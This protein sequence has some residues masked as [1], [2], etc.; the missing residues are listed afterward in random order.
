MIFT[1]CFFQASFRY[2]KVVGGAIILGWR[3]RTLTDAFR[4]FHIQ[5]HFTNI[6]RFLGRYRWDAFE[7]GLVLLQ[8]A[9][10]LL[11]KDGPLTIA[12]DVLGRIK[13]FV[14]CSFILVVDA[15][16]AKKRLIRFRTK[17]RLPSSAGCN[18]TRHCINR[19]SVRK[20][21]NAVDRENTACGCPHWQCRKEQACAAR[22]RSTAW[23][24]RC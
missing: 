19:L 7:V 9:I 13:M 16:Y 10:G 14:N 8:Y 20:V 17:I 23:R 12:I 4:F 1:G 11:I 22:P 5:G 15:L 3:R 2:F 24:C 21:A 6:H 18:L